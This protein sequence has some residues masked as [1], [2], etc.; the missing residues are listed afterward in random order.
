M[1]DTDRLLPR[2]GAGGTATARS[3]DKHRCARSVIWRAPSRRAVLTAKYWRSMPAWRRWWELVP[4]GSGDSRDRGA[5]A[6]GGA[7]TDHPLVPPSPPR[8]R[9][10][11]VAAK[12]GALA[13][14]SS[15]A[16]VILLC[17]LEVAK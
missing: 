15:T 16:R 12:V 2:R 11:A 9:V 14:S 10:E 4:G 6:V 17:H 1:R 8:L 7:D 3:D 13:S 5:N